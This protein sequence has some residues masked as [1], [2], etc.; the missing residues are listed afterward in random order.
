MDRA[1]EVGEEDE[2]ALEDRDQD[3]LAA[4]VVGGDL[5]AELVDAGLELVAGEIDLSDPRVR[6][7][8]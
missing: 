5:R 3:G 2:R 4:R 7:A 8:L 1:R 6:A